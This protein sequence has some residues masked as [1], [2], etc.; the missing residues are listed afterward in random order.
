M[1]SIL[2]KSGTLLMAAAGFFIMAGL[3]AFALFS[4]IL[5]IPGLLLYRAGMSSMY[6]DLTQRKDATAGMIDV[7]PEAGSMKGFVKSGVRKLRNFLN[8]YAD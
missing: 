1:T 7:T 4:F 2:L 3:V 5:L 6:N 8:K